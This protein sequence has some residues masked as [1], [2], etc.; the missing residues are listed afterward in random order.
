[1]VKLYVCEISKLIEAIQ[2]NDKVIEAYFDKLGK[3]RIEHIL[4]NSKAEDR[5]RSLGAALLLLF[6]LQNEMSVIEILPDFDYIRNAKPY[7]KQYPN[8]YFNIS[9][10]KNMVACAISDEEVGVDIEHKREIKEITINNVFTE[11]EKQIAKYEM[12]GYIRLWTMK[13]AYAKLSGK[14]V[15]DILDGLEVIEIE[16]GTMVQKL[17]P[18]IRK[19]FC[20][21]VVGEG[22]VLDFDKLPYYYSICASTLSKVDTIYTKW[23][24]NKI[25]LCNLL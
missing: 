22:K 3:K 13:E 15:A 16:N 6:A 23:D 19:T 24:D 21:Y 8:L 2:S 7:L 12:E 9:H 5:A 14:G 17:N 4:R 18:D 10:T 20:V 25:V 1:M 11:Q